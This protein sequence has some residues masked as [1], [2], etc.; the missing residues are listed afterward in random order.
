LQG[1]VFEAAVRVDTAADDEGRRRECDSFARKTV[2]GGARAR[3]PTRSVT[4]VAAVDPPGELRLELGRLELVELA[5]W[6][7]LRVS[8]M[9]A[10]RAVVE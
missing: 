5:D 7:L 8:R 4:V 3:V 10:R 1:W 2:L 9:P 6:R